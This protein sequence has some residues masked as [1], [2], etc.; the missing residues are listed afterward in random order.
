MKVRT[1]FIVRNLD[2][3]II[4]DLILKESNHGPFAPRSK[5]KSNG[6]SE[7]VRH[8]LQDPGLPNSGR[9]QRTLPAN[10]LHQMVQFNISKHE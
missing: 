6:R 2:Q 9:I 7:M 4:Q 8:S 3:L 1:T 10:S 5:S